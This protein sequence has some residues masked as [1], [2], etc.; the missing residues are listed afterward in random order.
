MATIAVPVAA[1]IS[2]GVTATVV[3]PTIISSSI[4]PS[5]VISAIVPPPVRPV[6]SVPISIAV[7]TVIWAAAIITIAGTVKDRHWDRQTEGKMNTGA[8]GRFS[9]ERQSRDNHQQNNKLLHSKIL[10]GNGLNSIKL[11]VYGTPI[12]RSD[13]CKRRNTALRAEMTTKRTNASTLDPFM[14]RN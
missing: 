9:D 4:V 12:W 11:I 5:A 10:D 2:A 3:T 8:G 1:T 13:H 7:G 14:G 6:V